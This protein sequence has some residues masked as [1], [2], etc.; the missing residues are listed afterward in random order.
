MCAVIEKGNFI[1]VYNYRR[2]A[3]AI[4]MALEFAHEMLLP[5]GINIAFH[6]KDGGDTCG[7]DNRAV[8]SA[9][10]WMREGVQCHIY[11]GPGC[12][13]SV[14][15]L[16]RFAAHQEVPIIGCPAAMCDEA[17]EDTYETLL[18][19]VVGHSRV[20]LLF[21]NAT[22]VRNMMLHAFSLGMTDG[23]YVYLAV[24]LFRSNYWG[25]LRWK[26]DDTRDR[27]AQLAFRSL[28]VIALYEDHN[29]F[30]AEFAKE[31]KKRSRKKYDYNY[32]TFEE[33]DFIVTSFYDAIV[34]YARTIAETDRI[35]GNITDG[36]S[37][38]DSMRNTSIMSPLGHV[39]NIDLDGDRSHAYTV[40]QLSLITGKFQ[41]ILRINYHNNEEI[42]YGKF[43]WP[44]RDGL[45]PDVPWCGFDGLALACHAAVGL[46]SQPAAIAGLAVGLVISAACIAIGLAC[47]LSYRAK[48]GQIDPYWW[49]VDLDQLQ[50]KNSKIRSKNLQSLG[51][52]SRDKSETGSKSNK[53]SS[54]A[55]GVMAKYMDKPVSVS[56]LPKGLYKMTSSMIRELNEV[57]AISHPNLHR[58]IGVG[59]DEQNFCSFILGDICTKGTLDDVLEN[60]L[61]KLDCSFKY[62]IIKDI[63][64]GMGYLHESI[65]G[66][67]GFLTGYNC[68]VD[69][70][71]LVK[72]TN[73][74]V[75]AFVDPEDL[76]PPE[77][78]Q[79]DSAR[80]WSMLLWRAPELLRQAMPP[81]GT[82]VNIL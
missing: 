18:G 34:L 62:S 4:D 60:E 72:I 74:G 71:F 10:D 58:I 70:R 43:Q 81:R 21:A 38:A 51:S 49:K 78:H 23:E 39:I 25:E 32:G 56:D 9:I 31:V 13:R 48:R 5:P 53:N 35:G 33:V 73:Y 12:D 68:S 41:D 77:K 29:Q 42:W 63:S 76:A 65:I 52:L 64:E 14:A 36:P 8:G 37:I 1:L 59:L 67:H 11:L 82:Q 69:S 54:Y 15:D 2:A 22:I 47:F 27:D 7:A 50:Y 40:K 30:F 79:S 44:G 45:P 16:Y 57:R 3:A 6:Y 20:I 80:N 26:Y 24:E 46:A 55:S 19:D 28:A 17:T 75:T 61:I 66:S